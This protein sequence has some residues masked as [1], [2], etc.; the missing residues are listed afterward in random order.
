[1]TWW[2]GDV[3]ISTVSVL[4][5]LSAL[6]YYYCTSTFGKWERLGVPY[7]RPLV[8]LFGNFW[9]VAIGVDHTVDAYKRIYDRLAGHGYGGFFQLRTPF[10]MIRDPA[11]VNRVLVTDSSYFPDH[12]FYTDLRTNPL[13]NH[14]FFM[15]G[16]RWH[17]MR[18]KLSPAFTSRKLKAVYGQIKE[19]SDQLMSNIDG[20][21]RAGD[22]RFDVRDVIAKYATDVIGTCAF[23]IKMNA[24]NDDSSEFRTY[25]KKLLAPSVKTYFRAAVQMIS[26]RLFEMMRFKDFPDDS[27]EFYRSIIQATFA[28]RESNEISGR[29]DIIHYLMMAKQDLVTNPPPGAKGI[30]L[31]GTCK[32]YRENDFSGHIL[33]AEIGKYRFFSIGPK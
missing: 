14:L 21:L 3:A 13:S 17:T 4:A 6:I 2:S 23:G 30:F 25:G 16:S 27:A 5:A 32:F 20:R 19:C 31:Q 11:L 24:V 10:L 22:D 28:Y 33:L 9:R 18:S 29:Q 7:A 8:P 15:E 1:M 26:P 12:G